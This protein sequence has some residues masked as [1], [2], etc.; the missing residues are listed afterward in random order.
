MNPN[1]L[2]IK[3]VIDYGDIKEEL[4]ITAE[5]SDLDKDE[6]VS[7]TGSMINTVSSAIYKRFKDLILGKNRPKELS[8]YIE[9]AEKKWQQKKT[10]S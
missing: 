6:L 9:E 2:I 10:K 1:P 7:I 8:D 5:V 4:D 3:V